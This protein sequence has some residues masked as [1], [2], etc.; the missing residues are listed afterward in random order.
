MSSDTT[1][2]PPGR[3]YSC[4]LRCWVPPPYKFRRYYSDDSS[5]LCGPPSPPP[6]RLLYPPNAVVLTAAVAVLPSGKKPLFS[7]SAPED[8]PVLH[9]PP[10]EFFRPEETSVEPRCG[11]RLESRRVRFS[12][13]SI[14]FSFRY[15]PPS[16]TRHGS[17][18]RN[19]I[20]LLPFV[21]Q[22]EYTLSSSITGAN[23]T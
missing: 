2:H 10:A 19:E 6:F 12:F 16:N 4:S 20:R 9:P 23:K 13:P 15:P 17:N 7:S 8:P 18:S 3:T 11:G 5:E 14:L 21:V 22:D 1:G